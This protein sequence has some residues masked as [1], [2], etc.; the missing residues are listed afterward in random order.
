[1]LAGPNS[2]IAIMKPFE[3]W[4]VLPHGR[5]TQIEPNL[6]TVTGDVKMPLAHL[7]RRM[8]VARLTDGRLVVFSAIALDE[9]EMRELERY[10]TPAFLVVPNDHHRLDA[11]AWKERYPD[12]QVVAPEGARE[13][14]GEIVPV[15]S[16]APDFGDPSVRYVTVAGT[17]N[18]EA[19]LL[20]KAD[21]G[22]TLVVNDLIGNLPHGQGV[23]GWLLRTMEFAGDE[24]HIPKPVKFAMI[25]DAD[26]VRAQLLEWAGIESLT[27]IVVSHGEPIESDPRQALRELAAT[28]H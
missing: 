27:R 3:H 28:L 1:M 12:M 4:T 7:Q 17:Q 6:L 24:P 23:G 14:V 5:L 21:G 9:D 11:R 26:A 18:G 25:E 22:T 13:K 10:G 19:A 15:D 8:T 2:G 16:T 20:V